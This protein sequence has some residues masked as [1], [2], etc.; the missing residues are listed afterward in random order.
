MKHRTLR[1]FAVALMLASPLPA[2]AQSGGNEWRFVVMPYVWLPTI[3]A[4]LIFKTPNGNAQVNAKANPDD[5]IDA[6]HYRSGGPP[7]D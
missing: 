7:P 3:D 1:C 4:T 6:M 2:A 5:Y